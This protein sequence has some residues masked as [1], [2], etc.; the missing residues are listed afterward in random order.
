M[1]D[2]RKHRGR[3]PEDD[4]LFDAQNVPALRQAVADLSWLLSHGYA[5]DSSLKLVGDR[6][7]L[8][9]RQRLAVQR[10]AC[11]DEAARRRR[12]G[13][14][15]L[16]DIR[17]RSLGVDG[18]NLLITVE[19]ALSGGLIL[20]GRDGCFRDL[21]S[22]HGTYRHVEETIPALERILEL[23]SLQAPLKIDWFLDRPVS[24][25]GRLKA[26]MAELLQ[27]RRSPQVAQHWDIQLVDSPDAEL[28]RYQ[29]IVATS[30]S[31]IL[32]ACTNWVNFAGELIDRVIPSA[33]KIDLR[34]DSH[35]TG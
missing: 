1:P 28:S 19:S 26:C 31:V 35:R 11:G 10:S 8:T 9:A 33:W 29:G 12:E 17:G 32:D 15:N 16:D 13:R 34:T 30:D 7:G 6:H 22:I 27:A 2:R 25:S 24:N 20:V 5:V 3:H 21:A 14:V 4:V 18:Y 23:I